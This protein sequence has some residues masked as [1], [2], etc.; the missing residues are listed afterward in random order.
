MVETL[1]KVISLKLVY[2]EG[3]LYHYND[4]YMYIYTCS[5]VYNYVQL[6]VGGI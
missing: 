4:I 1:A 5:C 2:R 6:H 3:L